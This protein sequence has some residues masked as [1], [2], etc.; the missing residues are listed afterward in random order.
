VRNVH[1][2][3]IERHSPKEVQSSQEYLTRAL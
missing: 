2:L 3:D 1:R